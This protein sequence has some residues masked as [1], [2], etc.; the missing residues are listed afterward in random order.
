MRAGPADPQRAAH[1][2]PSVQFARGRR[3]EEL[4]L[5][6]RRRRWPLI[7]R[8][9]TPLQAMHATF[10]GE[11]DVRRAQAALSIVAEDDRWPRVRGYPDGP[12]ANRYS[13]GVARGTWKFVQHASAV[14]HQVAVV[15]ALIAQP[16]ALRNGLESAHM[17]AWRLKHYL[18]CYP[19]EPCDT[20]TA[21][22]TPSLLAMVGY[23][24]A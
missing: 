9:R 23:L 13:A 14:V 10:F 11:N 22:H 3:W 7:G 24:A 8:V 2:R 12:G 6:L 20:H 16:Q 4:G 15:V 18:R 21:T 19:E 5:L 1:A 17:L